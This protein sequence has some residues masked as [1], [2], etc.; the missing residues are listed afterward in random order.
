VAVF[1]AEGNQEI[2]SGNMGNMTHI[3]PPGINLIDLS[4]TTNMSLPASYCDNNITPEI[5]VTN[6]STIY[7][8]TFE[9]SYTLNQNT[10]VTQAVYTALAPGANTT[11][12]FPTIIVP[13]GENTISYNVATMA[14]TSFIDNMP[15]NNLASSGSFNIL[16]PTAFATNH[17]EGFEGYPN[18]TP[19]PNNAI[20]VN[21]QGYRVF[22]I[23]PTF[24]G[25][26]V[27]GFG[28]TPNSFRW[29]FIQMSV[30]NYADL[31]FEK[32][33]FS[34]STG[35][36]MTYSYAHALQTGFENDRLQ[37][38]VSTDCG[39]TWNLESQLIGAA[40]ATTNPLNGSNFY[41]T[42]SDW[43]T[44]IVDLSAY[45]GNA[46]VMIAFK[47]VCA[48]GNNLYI[49]DIEIGGNS[50]STTYGCTDSTA[51]NYDPLATIN[52]GNCNYNTTSTDVQTACD[53]YTWI[54]GITYTS[55]NNSATFLYQTINGCDS[56]VTLD[57]T[58]NYSNTSTDVQTACDSYTW[59]DG[60]NYTASNNSAY[61]LLQS[62]NG[63]DSLVTLYLTINY[64]SSTTDIQQ[65]CDSYTW[66]DGTTYTQN[67][68]TT[69]FTTQTSNG[70]DSLVT[71]D[72]TITGNPVVQISQFGFDLQ[73]STSGGVIPYTF[74]WNTSETTQTITPT[75]N[76]WYWCIVVDNNGCTSDTAFINVNNI[77]S[78]LDDMDIRNLSIFPNPSEDIFN[79][80][81][82]SEKKQYIEIRIFN[83]LGERV[84]AE[85]K[86]QFFGEYT[87]QIDL[88][89]YPKAIYFLEIETDD[90][91][92]NKKLILQ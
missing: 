27:G 52:N 20:L 40:L 71:L 39:I 74:I 57:L 72:L 77:P 32:L 1:V 65:A 55:S 73:T 66:I 70:C 26:N 83:G 67:N 60:I 78:S 44:D 92:I 69:T 63:C 85:S 28:N 61:F 84:F 48:G 47:G 45:D 81:F 13:S 12:T 51:C 33:D 87:K 25:S 80:T 88:D 89:G 21:P 14:A 91:V 54:D 86:Q 37:I 15:S 43:A 8:D 16:S 6:N 3:V 34:G 30:G 36:T 29:Q 11:I 24:S 64:S 38:L 59:I 75:A 42:A 82:S 9:V 7:V 76:G 68:N 19:A 18:E 49:D 90:G 79:I 50:S 17:T 46:D 53:S 35:N 10:P 5:T 31:I 22:I 23:D 58:I 62:I 2:L 41:P 4:A 56:L